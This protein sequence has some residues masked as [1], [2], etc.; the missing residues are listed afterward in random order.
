MLVSRQ[1]R[2][3]NKPSWNRQ[4]IEENMQNT[5]G[6]RFTRAICSLEGLSVGDAL[7]NRFFLHPDTVQYLIAERALPAAPWPYT[8]D[9]QMA[10]SIIS[11]LRQY[12]KIKQE[13]LVASFAA[14]YEP[15][16]A[17]GP[18]MH[19]Q[20]RA[21]RE[22]QRWREMATSQFAGQGSFDNG[23]AMRIAP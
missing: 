23:A 19:Y 5:R 7:G 14:Y 9:T 22:G 1:M 10:L 17:Y 2:K 11:M 18:S 6:E 4:Y 16:R 21:L 3:L 12:G 20:L 15:A 8:D 13:H